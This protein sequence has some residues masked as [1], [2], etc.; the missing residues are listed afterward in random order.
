M[1]AIVFEIKRDVT[2]NLY[3][4]LAL[5][6]KRSTLFIID[7]TIASLAKIPQR[8]ELQRVLIPY[9]LLLIPSRIKG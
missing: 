6:G 3:W 5:V 9:Q 4:E 2:L 8:N 1:R 7:P